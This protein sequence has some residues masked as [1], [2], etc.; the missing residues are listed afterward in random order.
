MEDD[1]ALE[2]FGS[3]G[4]S[5]DHIHDVLLELL[6]LCVATRPTIASAASFLGNEDVFGIVEIGVCAGLDGIDD[7]DGG[8]STLGS[9]SMRMERG[10]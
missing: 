7:L 2:G 6:A 1:K 5:I 9:R 10:M 3:I 4:L 8:R